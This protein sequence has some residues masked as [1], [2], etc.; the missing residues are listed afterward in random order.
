MCRTGLQVFKLANRDHC[1]DVSF[2]AAVLGNTA[3][4]SSVNFVHIPT[5]VLSWKQVHGSVS[6]TLSTLCDC[7]TSE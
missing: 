5:K 7:T 2:T 3:R 1:I 6:H 4:L